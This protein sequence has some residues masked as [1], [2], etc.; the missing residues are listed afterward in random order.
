MIIKVKNLLD[1][2]AEY[3]YLSNGEVSGAGTIRVKNINA[4]EANQALQIGKTKE[5]LAEIVLTGTAAVSGTSLVLSGSTR[6]DHPTDTPVYAVR[7]DQIIFKRST[8]GTA[9]TATAWTASTVTITPD[10]DYTQ[11]YDSTG[12]STYAYKASYYN[13][14]TTEETADSDWIMSSG[15]TRYS[16]AKMRDRVKRKLTS[17]NYIQTDEVIDDWLNEWLEKMTNAAIDVNRD[18]LLGSESISMTSGQELGTITSTDFKEIRKMQVVTASGT[19]TAARLN[20]TDFRADQVFT[21]ALPQ[22]YWKGD[23][24]FGRKPVDNAAT[25]VVDYYKTSPALVDDTDEIPVSMQNYTKSFIDYAYAQACFLDQKDE[26]GYS[27]INMAN[28][29]LAQFKTEIAP[30]WKSGIQYVSVVSPLSS[31]DDFQLI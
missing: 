17:S 10:S 28:A 5:E 1:Q 7:F 18:Y 23:T 4:F 26:K 8:T 24:V 11:V 25:I 30:R 29:E 2:S 12:V 22:Y 3:S 14:V 6:F 31:E 20:I 27:F 15:Q 13:S 19:Q 16:L 21:E 9:G